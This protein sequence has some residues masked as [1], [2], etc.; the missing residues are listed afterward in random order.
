MEKSKEQLQ[1]ELAE[2]RQ[3]RTQEQA[4]ERIRDEVLS[5][6][7]SEDLLQV[8]L[9]MFRELSRLD[10]EAPAC[11]FFFVDEDLSHILWYAAQENPRRYGISWTSPELK[12]IDET[13]CVTVM[14]V[15]ITDDWE[16]DLG[17]WRESKV[18]SVVRS[19]EEDLAEMQPFQERLGFDRPLPFFGGEGWVITNVPFEYGW[20][21]MRYR[22]T[23]PEYIIRIEEW[24][25]TL[26]LG[27]LRN[28]DFQCLEERNRAL[29]EALHQLKATQS[30]LIMQE[31]MASLGSLVAG[32]AHE[33]NTP[34]GAITSMHDTLVRAL[35]KL[36][37]ALGTS[38]EFSNNQMVQSAFKV[39]GDASRVIAT[40]AH[41]VTDIVR[42]LRNFAR[43]DEAEF[44]VA[45]FHE[46][47]ES[48]LMLLLPQ[49]GDNIT[50]IKD[51]GDIEPI[52]CS[53][54]KLNQVF[55]RV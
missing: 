28:L 35:G 16:E 31:K 17:H 25:E 32:V 54:G 15:P 42:S 23:D 38:Q 53:P 36:E 5:M 9:V 4:V 50:V 20:V 21:A 30:Q 37:Q 29:E 12:E 26:S 33:M 13:T 48:T 51:Y 52:Y 24:T 34:L 22:G 3:Q 41:R 10:I 46:G 55:T 19:A 27:Y 1:I 45:D 6:R 44:Q 43:L 7:S 47:I 8:V 49:I 39:M 14:K 18:W 11:G 2:L 40:G